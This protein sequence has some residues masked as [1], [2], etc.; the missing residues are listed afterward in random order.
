MIKKHE[1][2]GTKH[3]SDP[4]AFIEISDTMDDV[5]EN[6]DYYNTKEK[7][8]SWLYLMIWLQ[9]LCQIKNFKP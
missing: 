8:K 1:D 3:F 4:N 6:I 2:A 9:A 7:E 5:Y